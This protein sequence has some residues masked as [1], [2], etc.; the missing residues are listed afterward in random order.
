MVP[1][2]SRSV[3]FAPAFLDVFHLHLL[4]IYA[5]LTNEVHHVA[6]EAVTTLKTQVGRVFALLALG[7][8]L[9]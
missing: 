6:N 3:S 4:Q 1:W 7:C 8:K 5:K 9:L 2:V